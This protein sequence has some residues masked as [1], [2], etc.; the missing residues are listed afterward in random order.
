MFLG[1]LH[2]VVCLSI[3]LFG[4]IYW[5]IWC[6][7]LPRRNGYTLERE[8]VIQEDGVSRSVFQKVYYLR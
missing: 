6:I 8:V 5:Y 3:A 1:Q 7:Y 2:V 4:V